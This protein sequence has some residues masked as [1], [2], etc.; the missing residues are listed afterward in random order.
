[1]CLPVL[2]G[3]VNENTKIYLSNYQVHAKKS[4]DNNNDTKEEKVNNDDFNIIPENLLGLSTEL[5]TLSNDN[6]LYF[7][8]ANS[9]DDKKDI[10]TKINESSKLCLN[11]KLLNENIPDRLLEP[12][13]EE[14]DDPDA[15]IFVSVEALI[16]LQLFSGN[17]ALIKNSNSA[18]GIRPVKVYT[19]DDIG[20]T[21]I[22]LPPILYNNL[23]L[24]QNNINKE[25]NNQIYI[26]SF[27]SHYI[28][29]VATDVTLSRI[30]SPY[31][32]EKRYLDYA[33]NLL[34]I[35]F[36]KTKKVVHLDDLIP[37]IV[38]DEKV[39]FNIKEDF[40]NFSSRNHKLRILFFK[41]TK[42]VSSNLPFGIFDPVTTK[43]MQVGVSHSIIP[44]GLNSY[45]NIENYPKVLGD[46]EQ[47]E[48]STIYN[49]ISSSLLPESLEY[50]LS[51]NILLHGSR[52]VGKRTIVY[53][54]SE[55][56]GI[57][58][59]EKN[60]FELLAES[61]TKTENALRLECSKVISAT[62]CIFL[63]NNIHALTKKNQSD[64]NQASKLISV[65]NDIIAQF[66]DSHRKLKLPCFIIATTDDIE[67]LS[68]NIQSLFRYQFKINNPSESER[69]EIIK[70]IAKG[71][72][73]APDISLKNLATQTAAFVA[74]DIS[75][76]FARSGS[77][78]LERILNSL[79]TKKVNINEND[80]IRAGVIINSEDIDKAL[81]KARADHSDSIGA[82][83][84]P[85]VTWDDVGGLQN[86]KKDI[87]DT[88]Q[89]PLEHPELFASGMKKRSG[90]LLF[91]PPGTGKTLVAKAIATT[92]SLN[93][94][95]V[96]GPEL[97]NMYVG[98]SEANVRRVFQRAR[99]ARPCVVFFDE[100]DS[101]APKR[102]AK[103]DSGGVMDR[104]VSQILAELDGVGDGN[105][106]AGDVFVI[107]A[108]NRPDLLDPALLRPGRKFNLHPDLDLAEIAEQCPFNY[109]GA[110]FY[111]L[112][113]DAILKA[114]IRTI[115]HID[116]KI[117]ELNSE[118]KNA[119]PITP[120]YYLDNMAEE[121]EKTVQVTKEDFQNALNELIPS[122]SEK[123]LEHYREIQQRF[124]DMLINSEDKK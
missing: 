31:T 99:D 59:Y 35:N 14:T 85:K 74:K 84:I 63:L 88:I 79:K 113:S 76:L 25:H 92:L 66:S 103:G 105:N 55:M 112:C 77:L 29:P 100:L 47:N 83:K 91:G 16:K 41:V 56:L 6:S 101:V 13:P 30:A 86:V 44:S 111:A 52:G 28:P 95:S 72:P 32:N 11:A 50:N 57:N 75:D 104:I 53:S 17:W 60:C 22:L 110:D 36:T 98:E 115:S 49:I 7:P 62:P 68:T 23:G 116:K 121:S 114:M 38:D 58:V 19:L 80:I 90:I 37:V 45:Y 39:K 93:F 119:N 46:G 118:N 107:G 108:T 97:L 117:D 78:A 1:M 40:N 89:L 109:T 73:L 82:P 26:Y 24:K 102:G 123:D 64:M 21:D 96:K 18:D 27:D 69:L 51:C 70:F 5:T 54:I 2:Q 34:K 3:Y 8:I 71:I 33:L 15:R 48:A 94:L 124:S 122:V 9:L 87:L 81:E 106:A 42:V 12:K 20:E 67:K 65:F 43:L 61:E 10:Y 120:A 4:I